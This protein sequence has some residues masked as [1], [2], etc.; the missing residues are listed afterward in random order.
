[1]LVALSRVFENLRYVG[2]IE[3][4]EV[5][6]FWPLLSELFLIKRRCPKELETMLKKLPINW[7]LPKGNVMLSLL[8]STG[9]CQLTRL[10]SLASYLPYISDKRARLAAANRGLD[11]CT[12][13]SVLVPFH[14]SHYLALRSTFE[15]CVVSKLKQMLN[16]T[17]GSAAFIASSLLH[18][19]PTAM[20]P[21]LVN[22]LDEALAEITTDGSFIVRFSFYHDFTM[23][24]VILQDSDS[25]QAIFERN[26][27]ALLDI[28]FD[29]RERNALSAL[30]KIKFGALQ[31]MNPDEQ[32]CLFGAWGTRFEVPLVFNI[33]A[34]ED[35]DKHVLAQLA[36]RPRNTGILAKMAFDLEGFFQHH[37]NVELFS[38]LRFNR[39][40]NEFKYYPTSIKKERFLT[41]LRDKVRQRS[42]T[43]LALLWN[44][45]DFKKLVDFFAD[46]RD[47]E[48]L[49]ALKDVAFEAVIAELDMN[50]GC[51]QSVR[52]YQIVSGCVEG[53]SI[54]DPLGLLAQRFRA[55]EVLSWL[56]F[57]L[58]R[59]NDVGKMLSTLGI[60]KDQMDAAISSLS[61]NSAPK[62]EL[63][64][65][66]WK[67]HKDDRHVCASSNTLPAFHAL[68][69][70]LWEEHREA[71]VNHIHLNLQQ[72]Y[73][74][75]KQSP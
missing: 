57:S 46:Q 4:D 52:T 49:K 19:A 3:M 55:A 67:F 16:P 59:A 48:G 11:A 37:F 61:Q 35:V 2:G 43:V 66:L 1:M 29:D 58:I 54:D 73:Q 42:E 32:D 23:H 74:S 18:F 71:F 72:Y 21:A 39:F 63:A 25:M 64:A 12:E 69:F 5:L 53:G 70:Y 50:M 7:P 44:P 15:P 60:S 33:W 22:A 36:N 45:S 65:V 51:W 68:W 38:D 10:N 62:D 17:P 34:R 56:D 6:A 9:Q 27:Q 13:N 28:P 75:E 8:I 30:N 41:L 31:D 24:P 47:E 14:H 26:N 20:S 40:L